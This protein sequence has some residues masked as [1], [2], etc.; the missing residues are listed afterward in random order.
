M[1]TGMS[2][3]AS[4]IGMTI[5]IT[6]R[7]GQNLANIWIPVIDVFGPVLG[8]NLE[9]PFHPNVNTAIGHDVIIRPRG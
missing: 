2:P 9:R 3:A 7:P 8:E 4:Y 1:R 6:T 5:G